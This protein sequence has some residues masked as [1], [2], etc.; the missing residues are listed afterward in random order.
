MRWSLDREHWP[1]I[2]GQ[3]VEAVVESKYSLTVVDLKL[4]EPPTLK[5]AVLIVPIGREHDY[6]FTR[7]VEDL[8]RQV[9]TERLIVVRS[10][11]VTKMDLETVKRDLDPFV[12]KAAQRGA[13]SIPYMT[14][15]SE[16]S[17]RRVLEEGTTEGGEKYVVEDIIDETT[18][19]RL[20]FGSNVGV[21]QTE[22]EISGGKKKKKRYLTSLYHRAIV[23]GVIG[24]DL[25]GPT[26]LVGL[27]GG[28]L[29]MAL[30]QQGTFPL[31]VVELDQTVVDLAEKY[32]GFHRS[33]TTTFCADG[34]TFFDDTPHEFNI[35]VIDVDA[36]DS[37]LGMSC[38]PSVFVEEPFLKKIKQASTGV[39]IFNVVAR[40]PTILTTVQETLATVFPYVAKL[41]PS[42]DDLNHLFFCSTASDFPQRITDAPTKLRAAALS[43]FDD[44]LLDDLSLVT[45]TAPDDDDVP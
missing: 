13:G 15:G 25:K 2:P 32:F 38:P 21:I 33:K 4:S 3:R 18:I 36:K 16:T 39:T 7:G 20:V 44:D 37:S 24:L 11:G 1:V 40:D 8:G 5:A 9:K 19:R 10:R 26:C 42:T 34:L 45:T 12:V 35:I 30:L 27:G 23:A 22:I 41:R 17:E 43:Q 31:T 14:A 29:A 28:A 6:V